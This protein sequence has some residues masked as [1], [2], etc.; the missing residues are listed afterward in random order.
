MTVARIISE[1]II[2]EN[3]HPSLFSRQ[4]FFPGL[5]NLGNGEFIVLFTIAEAFE[6]ANARTY[7]SRSVDQCRTWNFE[8]PLFAHDTPGINGQKTDH[9]KPVLL[10]DGT[11]LTAGYRITRPTPDSP[12]INE[13]TLETQP[14]ELAVLFSKDKGKSWTNPQTIPSDYENV[15]EISGPPLQL[16]DNSIIM[17]GPPFTVKPKIQK[18]VVLG[19][20][21]NGKNWA[22][23]SEYFK[24]PQGNIAP[25]ETRLCEM[26]PGRV[27]AIIWAFDTSKKIHL[28]NQVVYSND[29]G[30]SWSDPVDTGIAAQ[31]SNVIWL[32]GDKLLTIHSH[33]ETDPGV[34]IRLVDFSKNQWNIKEEQRIWSPISPYSQSGNIIKDFSNLKFGQPS[35]VPID[36]NEI[37]AVFWMAQSGAYK[38]NSIRLSLLK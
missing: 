30:S 12:T 1:N 36:N 8:G 38:I 16:S 19:S 10:N 25:Y 6:A 24:D 17:L 37:L 31:A 22:I 4:A 18:G 13:K 2:Y 21:D 32:G 34:S 3:P 33:R 29:G 35:L 23:K 15:L 9:F 14:G 5:S 27:I 11:L 28:N 7:I 20:S 26:Q